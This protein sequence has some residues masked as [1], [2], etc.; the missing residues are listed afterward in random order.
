[1]ILTWPTEKLALTWWRCDRQCNVMLGA[2]QRMV[3]AFSTSH[4]AWQI[5]LSATRPG[6]WLWKILSEDS[7]CRAKPAGKPSWLQGEILINFMAFRIWDRELMQLLLKRV[8]I[9]ILRTYIYI[10]VII[11]LSIYFVPWLSSGQFYKALSGDLPMKKG[12]GCSG[13]TYSWYGFDMSISQALKNYKKL[14]N[15][16]IPLQE[17]DQVFLG[18]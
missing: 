9:Y 18:G 16:G 2:L 13:K 3:G 17:Q 1:M 7:C 4:L 6:T 15:S 11:Y 5:C 14:I 8:Y 10:Y 12:F